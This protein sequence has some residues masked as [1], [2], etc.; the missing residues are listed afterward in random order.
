MSRGA[1]A[2][3]ASRSDRHDPVLVTGATGFVGR[4]LLRRLV[5]E[6]R[7][8]RALVR[9]GTDPGPVR[10]LGAAVCTGDV[11]DEAAVR[12]A[13]DGSALVIHL[14]AATSR[15]ARDRGD[16]HR[17]NVRGTE[18]LLRAAADA[19]VDRLVHASTTGVLGPT[20][21]APAD[22]GAPPRPDTAYRRSKLEGERRVVAAVRRTGLHA[23]V[24]RPTSI[25]GPGAANWAKL[26]EDVVH[27][28]VVIVGPGTHRFHLTYV[29]DVVE[30]LLL[31][32]TAEV[33]PGEVFHAGSHEVLTLN[34]AL[35]EIAAG[36]ETDLVVRRLPRQPVATVCAALHAFRRWTGVD[37]PLLH[38]WEFHARDRACSVEK[39]RRQLG[40]RSRVTLAEGAARTG[41]WLRARGLL[42]LPADPAPARARARRGT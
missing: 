1:R 37:V 25:Y 20:R 2:H 17:V 5:G 27:G 4:H 9:P 41:A 10:E 18:R 3:G 30:A 35:E 33:A 42:D 24:V 34:G 15:T 11:L 16:L 21:G 14:A 23:V 31:A 12:A 38:R 26:F 19:G 22:E 8:V 28:R 36:L 39:A 7:R 29:D 32:A 6:G 13:V 40:F